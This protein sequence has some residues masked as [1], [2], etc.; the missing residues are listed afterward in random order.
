MNK[1]YVTPNSAKK[2]KKKGKNVLE[3]REL[4]L[5]ARQKDSGVWRAAA[6]EK[7]HCFDHGFN[8]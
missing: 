7:L 1:T 3:S 8:M 6:A 4:K 5:M 2:K